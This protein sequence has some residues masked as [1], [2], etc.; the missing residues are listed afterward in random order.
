[1]TYWTKS[2]LGHPRDVRSACASAPAP[3]SRRHASVARPRMRRPARPPEP[4]G[5]AITHW[6]DSTELFMEHPALIV[7]APDKFAVHLT[8]LT[9]FAPLRSGTDHAAVR[10]AQGGGAPVVVTQDAPRAPG[11]YGPSPEFRRPGV[12]D[13]TIT[14]REPAGARQHRGARASRVYASAAEAPKEEGGETPRHRV[15]QGAAVEDAG[16]RDGVRHERRRRGGRSRRAARSCPRRGGSRR[17]SAPIGGLVDASGVAVSPAPGQRVQRGQVL[18]VLTP[19]LGERVAART[20]RRARGCGRR[21]TSTTRAKRLLRGR[22]GARSAACTKPRSG[23]RRRARRSPAFGGRRASA[24]DGRSPMR[25][26]I[27]GVVGEP[28]ASC[29]AAASMRA[30]RCS[31]SSTRRSCGSRSTCRPR[32]APRVS[33]HRR[34]PRSASRAAAARVQRRRGGVGGKRDRLALAHACR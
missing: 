18:A 8:D 1:M 10:A 32:E 7:G 29:P 4:A 25:A 3:D 20:P 21:R 9:D 6:T 22:G 12:Y 17:S 33:A 11:I 2:R 27:A 31:R 15:P 28:H 24:R 26:P 13:L 30:R 19:A 34:A 16:V 14:G 5:G 23:S